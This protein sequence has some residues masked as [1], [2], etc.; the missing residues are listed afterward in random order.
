MTDRFCRA[1]KQ[2]VNEE[3]ASHENL[4]TLQAVQ[5]KMSLVEEELVVSVRELPRIRTCNLFTQPLFTATDLRRGLEL[6]HL[7][8]AFPLQVIGRCARP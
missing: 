8:P 1:D 6:P 7:L 4:S 5:V 3:L 2:R